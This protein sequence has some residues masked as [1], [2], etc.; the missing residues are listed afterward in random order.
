VIRLL[1]ITDGRYAPAV[2]VAAAEHMA[3]IL[4][5]SFAVQLRDRER[6]GDGTGVAEA[7][8]QEM[9]KL[10]RAHGA[11]LFVNR[12]RALGL[13]I[14]ADGLHA[15]AGELTTEFCMRSTPI[16]DD[17]ELPLSLAR[18][19]THLLVSPIFA[20]PGKGSP[21]GLAALAA[22][23]RTGAQVLALGGITP[24]SAAQ[25]FAAGATGVAAIR[26][27]WEEPEALAEACKGGTG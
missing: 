20:T 27:A 7:F 10:T 23:L 21:R 2:M 19:A 6:G 24:L 18:G 4:G 12:D 11:A 9:R 13:C 25:A 26:A 1:A 8:A 17:A 5:P 22:P 15:P 14:E 3:R 16:H